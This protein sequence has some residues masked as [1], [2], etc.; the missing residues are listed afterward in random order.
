MSNLALRLNGPCIVTYRGVTLYSK[1][2]V[3]LTAENESFD[4]AVD[5]F[6]VI[7]PRSLN[8]NVQVSFVPDGRYAGF[9]GILYPYAASIPGQLTTRVRRFLPAAVTIGTEV[10]NLPL[11]G[12]NN[13]D[14]VRVFNTGGALPTGLTAGTRYFVGQTDANNIKLYATRANAVALTSPIDL[15]GAGT[16]ENSLIDQEQLTILS[17]DGRQYVFDVAAIASMPSLNAKA[18]DTLFDT[19]TFDIFRGANV[20]ATTAGSL[21]ALTT[22][23]TFTE[24][25]LDPALILT[26]SYLFSW[27]AAPWAALETVDGFKWD[28]PM[29]TEDVVDDAGGRLGRR[30]TNLG[31]SVSCQPIG[32]TEAD[33]TTALLLQGAGAQRGGRLGGVTDFVMTGTGVSVTGKGMALMSGPQSFG[34]STDRIGRLSWRGTR[35]FNAGV[36]YPMFSVA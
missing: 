5:R 21:F 27:G 33:L 3:S 28:F 7:E 8:K 4:V 35:M 24:P 19:V 14:A 23:V 26:Q 20:A 22:G 29:A 36:P 32:P 30:I 6:G 10:I 18:S 11:H 12:Y 34:R 1:G 17:A 31:C 15:T 13:G 16:G 9:F 2:D 25:G